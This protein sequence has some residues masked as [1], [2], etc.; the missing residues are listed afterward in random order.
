MTDTTRTTGPILDALSIVVADMAATVDFYTHL[1]LRFDPGAAYAPHAESSVGPMRI[2]F[3]TRAVVES[4]MPGWTE[5]AGGHRMALAFA[6]ATP[7]DVDAEHTALVAAGHRSILEPF[8]AFW[9]QRYAVIAD[10]DGNPV[11]LY[12]PLA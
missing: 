1:G 6:C 9:G 3:D 7:A 11:D 8:D 12:S 2:L 5:P 10:P 4:F